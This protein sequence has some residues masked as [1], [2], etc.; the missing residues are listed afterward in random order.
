MRADRVSR[1][2]YARLTTPALDAFSQRGTWFSN[3]FSTSSYTV[4]SHASIM[5]GL[6]PSYHSAGLHNGQVSLL[7]GE[8]TLA[9]TCSAAGLRTAAIVSNVVLRRAIGL[10]QGF[11]TYDDRM[12]NRESIRR[13]PERR[14]GDAITKAIAALEA[15]GTEPFFLWIH[16]QDPHG[17]YTP[18]EATPPPSATAGQAEPADDRILPEGADH[19]GFEAIPRY[20]LFRDERRVRQYVGRY[21]REIAFVDAQ[22]GRLFEAAE[23]RGLLARTLVVITADHG[24]ALGEDGY[25]FGHSHSVGLDQVRV[26]LVIAGPG[27]RAG[28]VVDDPVTNLAVYAT[29]LDFLGLEGPRPTRGTSL[30]PA[31]TD[32][33]RVPQEPFYT[34]SVAQRG[35]AY[36]GLYL[37][38]DRRPADDSEF[39]RV[40]PQTNGHFG[41]Q[42]TEVSRILPGSDSGV[43]PKRVAELEARLDRYGV[44]ADRSLA[45]MAQRSQETGPPVEIVEELRALGYA[46]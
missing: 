39:W 38:A 35:I 17:P 5:T 18:P 6:Y 37:R 33:S 29:I 4:P 19:S 25:Y 31:L 1:A 41:P 21:D 34:E 8:I 13:I 10:A 11:E 3:A 2:G 12:P 15:F 16:L 28:R 43:D 36:G 30:L 23:G 44:R 45:E 24:E 26:P 9:E 27:L 42:G 7:P 14:A 40:N 20:Q 46:E 32:G 22:L